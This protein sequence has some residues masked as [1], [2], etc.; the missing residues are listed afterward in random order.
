MSTPSNPDS[1]QQPRDAAHWAQV[2][3]AL[4]VGE[5]PPGAINLNVE[6]R[7]VVGP[8]QGF[9]PLWQKTY[10]VRLAGA[11]ATP[12]EVVQVWK[13]RFQ[14]LQPPQ[15]R[16]YA[17][18]AGVEPGQVVL[19]NA[20]MRGIPVDSG[21]MVIYSDEESFTLMTPEGCPEAGWIMCSAFEED[22]ATVAQVQT[23]GR[24]N[25]PVYEFG[26]RFMGG[27]LEQEKIWTHVLTSLA[28][29]FGVNGQVLMSKSCLDPRFQWSRASNVWRNASLRS[30][31]YTMTHPYVLVRTRRR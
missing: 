25:D 30:M 2:V 21:V 27:A 11:Q 12:V 6:G 15:N 16:F 17:P 29:H 18:R 31:L 10:R 8:L 9:G 22:S 23:Q 3:S 4:K 20:T 5:V 1:S 28:A 13:E 14:S 24:S 26:F 7:R 19:L